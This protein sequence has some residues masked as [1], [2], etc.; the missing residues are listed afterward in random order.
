MNIYMTMSKFLSK[1][2]FFFF[3]QKALYYVIGE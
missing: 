2:F 1:K 3:H